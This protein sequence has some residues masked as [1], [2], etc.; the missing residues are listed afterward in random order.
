MSFGALSTVGKSGCGAV[1]LYNVWFAIGKNMN[2]AT[3]VLEAEM[4][5]LLSANGYYD[6]FDSSIPKF[7]DAHKVKY[8]KYTS[9]KEYKKMPII[10]K[11]QYY[12]LILTIGYLVTFSV[13]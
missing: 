9:L 1:A 10:I 4:N 6:M 7:L 8:K 11:F 13:Y 3:I 5:G 12:V 2:L